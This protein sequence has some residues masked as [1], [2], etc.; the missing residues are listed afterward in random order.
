MKGHLA[1]ASLLGM[2]CACQTTASAPDVTTPLHAVNF[3]ERGVIVVVTSNGCTRK[4]DF[5]IH[6]EG[7][8][9]VPGLRIQRDKHDG[10]RRKRF[11]K[12]LLFTWRELGVDNGQAFALTNPLKPFVEQRFR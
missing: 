9:A 8:T 6:A 5:S 1:V 4:G 2:L 11:R 7:D 3:E 10:C 12:K